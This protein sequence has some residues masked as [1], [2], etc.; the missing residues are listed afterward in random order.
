VVEVR[1]SGRARGRGGQR[2]VTMH[3]GL[4]EEEECIGWLETTDDK[5]HVIH[6][7]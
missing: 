4:V 7:N 5:H 1:E 2:K 3:N 6:L